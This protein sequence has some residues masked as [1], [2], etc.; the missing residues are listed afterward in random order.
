ML[1]VP[2]SSVLTLAR[3][4]EQ[5]K[6]R[7]AH[8]D[9]VSHL[10]ENQRT[11]AV[12][13][14]GRN[15]DAAIHRA[16]MHRDRIGRSQVQM[17]QLQPVVHGVLAHRG[18]KSVRLAFALN[19]QNHHHIGVHQRVFDLSLDAHALFDQRGKLRRHQRS[20]AGYAHACAQL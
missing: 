18:N 16:G 13:D 5:V 9:A 10:L 20:R 15:L 19:A 6:H 1:A 7:H 12:G 17:T 3:A 11:S 4:G 2:F 8:G 14:L